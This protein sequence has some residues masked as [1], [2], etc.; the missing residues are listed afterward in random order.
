MIADVSDKGMPAA[1]YMTVTR[2]LI[3]ATV[4]EIERPADVLQKVNSLMM[5]NNDAGLFVTAV[6]AILDTRSGELVYANAGH[7]LPYVIRQGKAVT[8]LKGGGISLGAMPEIQL[9][10]HTVTLE[11]GD[12]LLLYT[13]G[14]TE[15]FSESGETFGDERLLET[16]SQVGDCTSQS[17]I[18]KVQDSLHAFRGNTPPSDDVTLVSIHRV[19]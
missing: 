19:S 6:Y 16:L 5:A 9:P 1:L 10:E 2:T 12:C 15:T 8:A 14:V 7:N 13:D 11:K 18:E 3:R 17:V 4:R